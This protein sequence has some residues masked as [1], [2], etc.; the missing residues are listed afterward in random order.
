[1]DISYSNSVYTINDSSVED[2]DV[3]RDDQWAGRHEARHGHCTCLYSMA[4]HEHV[5]VGH[6][7]AVPYPEF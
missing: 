1:M 5:S 7:R 3:N 6:V 4:R 2:D